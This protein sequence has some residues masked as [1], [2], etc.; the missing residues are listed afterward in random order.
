MV[1]T[2]A[3]N[4]GEL[5]AASSDGVIC[6][7]GDSGVSWQPQTGKSLGVR[8]MDVFGLALPVAVGDV[9]SVKSYLGS[10]PPPLFPPP[11][12]FM[13][14]RSPPPPLTPGTGWYQQSVGTRFA[15]SLSPGKR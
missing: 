10:P 7:S 3:R 15:A 14:P 8:A 2:G 1:F 5:W 4:P 9:G 13:P 11:G 12:P 6:V